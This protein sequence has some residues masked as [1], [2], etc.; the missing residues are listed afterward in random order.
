MIK[1]LIAAPLRQSV[2]IFREY[3]KGLDGLVIPEGVTVDRFFVVNDCD[4]VIPEIRGDYVICNTGDEYRK[5]ENDH[6]WT[7]Q[8]LDKMSYLRNVTIAQTLKGGYDYLFSVDTDLVLQPQTLQTLLDAD[9]DIIS[10]LF[11]TN[12]W[13]NAWMWD[14]SDGMTTDWQV[15]GQ[16]K[17]G[18]TGACMLVKRRVFEHGVSYTKIPNIMYALR[19]E[20]RHFGVRAACLGFEMW[21]D[22]TCPPI[23]LYTDEAYREYMEG[24]R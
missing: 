19:G 12:H 9:K 15:P 11:Y 23:H 6:L 20:D 22:S 3:Q 16:Y 21:T 8:N 10:E 2:E 4:E 24:K 13:C 17:V 1:I 5:A 14:Q 7:M 18:F